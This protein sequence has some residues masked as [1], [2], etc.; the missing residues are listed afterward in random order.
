[1]TVSN[2]QESKDERWRGI[3]LNQ[4]HKVL[5]ARDL[6]HSHGISQQAKAEADKWLQNFMAWNQEQLQVIQ[7]IKAAKGGVVIVMGPAGTGKTLLQMALAIYFE[8]LGFHILALSPANSNANQLASALHKLDSTRFLRLYPSSRDHDVQ[9]MAEDQRFH[10]DERRL[11]QPELMFTIDELTRGDGLFHKYG[12][13]EAVINAAIQEK[14]ILDRPLRSEGSNV[15]P[16]VNAWE[17]L[18]EFIERYKG[19]DLANDPDDPDKYKYTHEQYRL[20]YLTCK[21][22][23]FRQLK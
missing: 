10:D 3:L 12:V 7:G 13:V 19:N 11:P 18:R 2:L 15:G 1:M 16:N 5:E 6:T 17:I 23:G 9:N 4:V 21:G 14:L 8:K 22:T 20:A